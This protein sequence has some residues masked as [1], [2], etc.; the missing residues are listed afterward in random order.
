MKTT[1]YT[2]T[3]EVFK[4]RG[5]WNVRYVNGAKREQVMRAFGTDTLPTP[6]CD[7]MGFAE[8]VGMLRRMPS[9]ADVTFVEACA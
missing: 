4:A 6:F 7:P 5:T 1:M 9:N 8:V 3:V 2:K